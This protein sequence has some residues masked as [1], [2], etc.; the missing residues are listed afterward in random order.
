VAPSVGL[1]TGGDESEVIIGAGAAY[2]LGR[3][4]DGRMAFNIQ[5]HF[6][7]G[8]FEGGSELTIPLVVVGSLAAGSTASVFA[9]AGL[10]FYRLSFSGTGGSA[11]ATDSNPIVFGGVTLDMGTIDLTG[12]LQLLLADGSDVGLT[13]G[14]SI[15][16]G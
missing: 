8:S 7:R 16:I 10:Q 13:V 11:S 12:G 15:P 9:G 14:A 5:S 3:N 6:A 4:A 1:C 2:S